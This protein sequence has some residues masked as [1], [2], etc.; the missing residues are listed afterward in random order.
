MGRWKWT[1]ALQ[2]A[3]YSGLDYQMVLRLVHRGVI[4]ALGTHGRFKIDI[5]LA[6]AALEEEMRR[7]K[8]L[9]EQPKKVFDVIGKRANAAVE[10]AG[11]FRAAM[12]ALVK[13]PRG[14]EATG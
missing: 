14:E 2:Y 4:P 6:D 11:G 8:P 1:T 10:A 12:Q 3:E 7:P 5:D 13:R 9:P